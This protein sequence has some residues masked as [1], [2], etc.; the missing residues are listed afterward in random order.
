MSQTAE[1][2]EKIIE[3]SEGAGKLNQQD[4]RFEVEQRPDGQIRVC[5]AFSKSPKPVNA[6]GVE[7]SGETSDG[8]RVHG[9]GPF[10][11][12]S[13]TYDYD[14]E[15][16]THFIDYGLW[17]LTVGEAD[18][19][20]AH[21][22]SFAITN[23]LFC[24]NDKDAGG[25][26]NCFDALKLKLDSSDVVFRKVD[27]YNKIYVPI[28]RGETTDV[29]CILTVEIDGRSRDQMRKMVNRV[30]DLLTI[31]Q[32]R[33]IEWVNYKVHDASS[34]WI[35]TYHAARRT[36]PRRGFKLIDFET[37]NTAINY[38]ERGYPAYK[39]FQALHPT[40]LNGIANIMFDTNAVRFTTIHALSM[41]C[42]VDA[43]GKSLL[44]NQYQMKGKQ[45]KNSYPIKEKVK[46][47]KCKYNVCLSASDIEYFRLSRNSVVHELIFH[48]SD[49]RLENKKCHHIFHRI[50]LR[51]LDYEAEYFNITSP[52]QSG[53]RK[54]KLQT[55]P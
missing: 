26:W 17:K 20:K 51:I 50:L 32:G 49:P 40:L 25:R 19:S 46:A 43:L 34:S 54:I 35:F 31:A 18:W 6:N 36:D 37:A 12:S 15:P 2:H 38:L 48:T 10:Q 1:E 11:N 7:L 41:F 44:D 45:T 28:S 16:V 55:C 53:F 29:T 27:D 9:T 24:G 39:R 5:C 22:V 3:L 30:C 42:M 52:H 21:S 23:F 4:C 13:T 47:L 33:R 8:K 14:T